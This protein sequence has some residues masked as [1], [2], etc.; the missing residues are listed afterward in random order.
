MSVKSVRCGRVFALVCVWL[1]G[2]PSCAWAA[3]SFRTDVA[4]V[5]LGKCGT[6]HVNR[7]VG[8]VSMANYR[9]LM[10]GPA[11]GRI[12]IPGDADGSRLIEVIETGD[13]PRGGGKVSAEQLAK[14]KQWIRE[15]TKFD[16]DDPAANLA[17]L[18]PDTRP[19][20]KKVEMRRAAGTELVSFSSDLAPVL[21][22]HCV[23]CHGD[24]Q[25][26]AR[27][28][29][30]SYQGLL[31]GGD[32]GPPVQPGQSAA[33]LLIRKLKGEAD[34]QRM[35][36]GAA[37]LDDA[38]IA[39]FATWIQEGTALDGADPAQDVRELAA[40][41]R[42]QA[43][44]DQQLRKDRQTLAE[45]NWRLV[46]PDDDAQQ[47]QTE[48]FFL[49]GNVDENSL[50]QYGAEAESLV[51]K[52]ARSLRA[53]SDEP[54]VKGAITLY[55]FRTLYDYG[56]LGRMVERRELAS[57]SHAHFRFSIVDAYGAFF[58]ERFD[59]DARE[60]LLAEQITG[61][62]VASLGKSPAWF[63]AGIG[64]AVAARLEP[65][66]DVVIGWNEQ[67][68]DA[69]GRVQQP[70]DFLNGK[71]V[72][73]DAG[74]L[75]YSFARFLMSDSRRFQALLRALQQG[76][77]FDAAFAQSYQA[78]PT[79]LAPVWLARAVAEQRRRGGRR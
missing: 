12:V 23:D 57:G 78:G 33:S 76:T 20:P 3:I 18:V 26:R 21:A 35:P 41:A 32:N 11:A 62:Y 72:A 63:S 15:G 53:P 67:L 31:R 2:A 44:T 49:L 37:P 48:H 13:M 1:C 17:T 8:G 36:Q 77:D 14:L 42:A 61:V 9:A 10:A 65:R 19:A 55:F 69:L 52:I 38:V 34:G 71:G 56:E 51:P 60:T 4:P 39:Q 28:N 40:I 5:L 6:C 43:A 54:F 68:T 79:Q 16:G 45:E 29:L 73:E 64:R 59:A 7:E 66:S 30:T 25:P 74:L 46:M 22:Q 50:R 27:L 70:D 75:A 47:A 24:N 58:V